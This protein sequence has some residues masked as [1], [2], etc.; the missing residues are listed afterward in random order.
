MKYDVTSILTGVFLL[1]LVSYLIVSLFNLIFLKVIKKKEDI[2]T[3]QLML[4][5]V[6][7][8]LAW[9]VST[10]LA[11]WV[12]SSVNAVFFSLFALVLIFGFNYF[13]VEKFLGVSGKNKIIYSALLAVILNP[14]WL[15]LV[16]IL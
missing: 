6:I 1:F 5:S 4:A 7:V 3:A 14:G 12:A 11:I 10:V 8:V 13:L 15:V 9:M 16:G 2:K